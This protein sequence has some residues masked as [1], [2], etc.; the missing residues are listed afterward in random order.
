MNDNSVVE[1]KPFNRPTTAL[2]V[3]E[4]EPEPAKK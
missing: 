1:W 4:G 3:V 2:M